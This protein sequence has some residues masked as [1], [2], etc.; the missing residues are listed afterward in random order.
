MAETRTKVRTEAIAEEINDPLLKACLRVA[1]HLG[2]DFKVVDSAALR[3]ADFSLQK[4]AKILGV[5]FRQVVLA[6]NWWQ[7]DGGPFLAYLEKNEEPVALLPVSPGRYRLYRSVDDTGVPLDRE[8]AAKLLPY[9]YSLYPPFPSSRLVPKDILGF[10]LKSVW[11]RDWLALI[12][13]GIL[14]GILGTFIP[15]MTG[16]LFDYVVPVQDYGQWIWIILLLIAGSIASFVFQLTRSIALL[17]M[18]GKLDMGLE[19]ALWDR[20]LKLPA[21]FFRQFSAGDLAERAAGISEIR[22]IISGI[23]INALLAGIFSVFNLA[24]IFTYSRAAG[25]TT[26]G[27]AVLLLTVLVLH[28]GYIIKLISAKAM[29]AGRIKGLLYQLLRGIHKFM[30]SGTEHVAYALWLK[31]F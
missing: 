25:W 5:R 8:T 9:V 19:S 13:I 14:G 2:V 12:V 24:L 17:R 4:A 16:V 15:F 21:D 1:G 7:A 22:K 10:G 28:F 26:F 20:I 6:G 18:E 11:R 27:C 23:T 3:G 31:Q 29:L 30:V